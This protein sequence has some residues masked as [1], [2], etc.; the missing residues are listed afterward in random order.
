VIATLAA[1]LLLSHS[2][3]KREYLARGNFVIGYRQGSVWS[4]NTDKLK[5]HKEAIWVHG[6]GIGSVSGKFK[7]T[8]LER[9]T[10]GPEEVVLIGLR[11][12]LDGILFSGNATVPR[13]VKVLSNDNVVYRQILGHYLSAKGVTQSPRITKLIEVD[14]NGDGQQEVI[15]EA[16]SRN[17]LT[18]GGMD[19]GKSGDYSIVLLRA[20]RNGKAVNLPLAFDHPK[21]G[22]MPYINK[23]MAIADLEGTGKMQ[24]IVS[25]DY[26]EGISAAVYRLKNGDAK[27]IVDNGVGA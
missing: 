6:V 1:I 9:E 8:G 14:L 19:A 24:V 22:G 12:G 5:T 27:Q 15:I 23:I 11:D 18:A 7:A 10:N 26:Y 20:V 3:P 16:R 25:S 21:P 4:K 2:A 17:D 13:P